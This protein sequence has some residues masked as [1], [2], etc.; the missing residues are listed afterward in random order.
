MKK[1]VL[2]FCA[3]LLLANIAFADDQ[4]DVSAPMDT[5]LMT[6]ENTPVNKLFR[7]LANCLTFIVELPASICDITKR[8]GPMKGATLGVVDGIFTSFMRLGTGAFDT[9]T[10]LIP[11]YNKPI[12]KPEYALDSASDKIGAANTDW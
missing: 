8:K 2:V 9:V 10:F 3:V 1:L 4:A 11:P 6:L 12:L 7:G 5:R